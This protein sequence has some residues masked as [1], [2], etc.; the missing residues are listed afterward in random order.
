MQHSDC[1]DTTLWEKAITQQPALLPSKVSLMQSSDM[2][3]AFL[4]QPS[5]IASLLLSSAHVPQRQS[6]ESQRLSTSSHGSFTQASLAVQESQL[7]PAS[8]RGVH[9]PR[10][11]PVVLKKCF[12]RLANGHKDGNPLLKPKSNSLSPPQLHS[13]QGRV[14]TKMGRIWENA[15]LLVRALVARALVAG[16]VVARA[17]A[18]HEEGQEPGKLFSYFRAAKNETNVVH[19]NHE[20]LCV[21]VQRQ[22]VALPARQ[23][24]APQNSRKKTTGPHPLARRR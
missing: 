16:A 7:S 23:A 6:S 17:F 11:P 20:E 14:A 9:V 18:R 4:E 15:F 3:S 13:P 8:C 22:C 21:L 24:R 2:Q 12:S 5:A 19:S 10:Q 1:S